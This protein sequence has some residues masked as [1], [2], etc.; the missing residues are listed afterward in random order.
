MIIKTVKEQQI[1]LRG[2]GTGSAGTRGVVTKKMLPYVNMIEAE[3]PSLIL[4][5]HVFVNLNYIVSIDVVRVKSVGTTL[6][7]G[8]VVI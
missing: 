3:V 5:I 4:A 2:V 8:S 6:R 7:T 1:N